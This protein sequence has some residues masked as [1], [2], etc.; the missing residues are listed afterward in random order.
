[1]RNNPHRQWYHYYHLL[2]RQITVPPNFDGD[3][4]VVLLGADAS[5]VDDD[6]LG[7]TDVVVYSE[8]ISAD[9]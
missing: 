7:R 1:M 4:F 5:C 2:L 9:H 6:E 8:L 3:E